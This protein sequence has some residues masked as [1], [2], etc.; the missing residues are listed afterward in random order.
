MLYGDFLVGFGLDLV[1]DG[2]WFG[3]CQ[4]L[5]GAWRGYNFCYRWLQLLESGCQ[6][7]IWGKLLRIG[8]LFF[9][10]V[11]YEVG[12]VGGWGGG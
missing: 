3:V 5:G 4:F 12:W 7:V 6:V 10:L 1:F 9:Y 8:G 2:V 11:R